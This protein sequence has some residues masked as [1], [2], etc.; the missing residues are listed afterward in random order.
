MQ[1][2]ALFAAAVN[3]LAGQAAHV[4]GAMGVPSTEAY[5]PGVQL[6]PAVVQLVAFV[7]VL[8]DNGAHAAQV[9]FV[10]F[11]PCKAIDCPGT[12][13]VYGVQA[14]ALFTAMLNVLAGQAAHTSFEVALPTVDAYWPA[15]HWF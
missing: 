6:A 1:A 13:A 11:V 5:W 4:G 9:W 10:I 12:H 15:M 8:Y 7:V 3:V 14:A 2:A